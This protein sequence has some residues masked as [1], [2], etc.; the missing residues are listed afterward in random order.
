MVLPAEAAPPS[1]PRSASFDPATEDW[2]SLKAT[3]FF[4]EPWCSEFT[5]TEPGH[6]VIA[7]GGT[8]TRHR[9]TEIS[10]HED[11]GVSLWVPAGGTVYWLPDAD[12]TQASTPW[13]SR[14]REWDYQT[15]EFR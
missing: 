13:E 14:L 7:Y 3:H 9:G 12:V 11:G 10:A 15:G 8:A 4:F 2:V 5:P 6:M 1:E